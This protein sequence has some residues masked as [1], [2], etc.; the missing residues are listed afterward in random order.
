VPTVDRRLV[1]HQREHLEPG[2]PLEIS[3]REHKLQG[4]LH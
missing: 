1:P 2:P 4:E 3:E